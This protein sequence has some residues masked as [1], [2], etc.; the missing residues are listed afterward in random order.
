MNGYC[1]YYVDENNKSDVSFFGEVSGNFN[2]CSELE[3]VKKI[4][5]LAH[6]SWIFKKIEKCSF[7][8]FHEIALSYG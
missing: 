4:F 1:V 8:R 7:E 3:I 5:L 2:S 6:P